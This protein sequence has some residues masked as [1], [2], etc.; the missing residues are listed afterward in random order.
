MDLIPWMEQWHMIPPSGGVILC[1]VSGGRDSMC[2]LHYLHRLGAKRGFLVAAG[3]LN[4]GMRPTAARDEA[5]V[6]DFC[7]AHGVPFYV[8][9]ERVYE[10]AREWELSV[11]ETGRRLRY[12]FLERTAD[13]IGA[14]YIAT[15]HHRGDQAETVL[16]NL[17]RGTGSEGL[18]GIPPVRGRL[19]RPLLDTPREEIE[20]YL[21]RWNVA[22][23]EDETN[24]DLYYARN[25]LRLAVWPELEKIHGAAR[26]NIVRA[27]GIL[28]R[29]SAYL[30]E[31]AEAFLPS[32]GTAVSCEALKKA[33]EA[34]RARILHRL[35]DR[36]P[37]GKK[38]F[39]AAHLVALEHLAHTGGMLDLPGGVRAVCR[40]GTF[41]LSM[42]PD[43][44]EETVL[45]W[46]RPA[47]WGGYTI[48]IGQEARCDAE[49]AICLRAGRGQLITVRVWHSDD[50]LTLPGSR[51]ARSLKRLFAE[52]GIAPERREQVP[53]FCVDGRA[54]AA[55]GIG[56]DGSFV[57]ERG[58][59]AV[60]ITVEKRQQGGA[61]V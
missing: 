20:A 30:D 29:E 49:N 45:T 16:L 58:A 39:G 61:Q 32:E 7:A 13:E 4:H 53:V 10:Q 43:A 25:R 35:I 60:W 23:V 24:T 21:Q 48:R 26:E 9:G 31:Q 57:P 51:G 19:I 59:A 36:L 12:A 41:T 15:A 40:E 1:A 33:P 2:L 14:T 52:A 37:C 38:D 44:P 54:A 46:D 28:R 17:L 11:E 6:R 27:A 47:D 8:A 50:R 5:L 34:L 56:T 18:G 55:C 42:A 22:Y 3:H